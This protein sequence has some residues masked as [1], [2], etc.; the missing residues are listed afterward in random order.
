VEDEDAGGTPALRDVDFGGLLD[1]VG[2]EEGAGEI[3]DG[4]AAP[5]HDEAAAVGD[6]G[7]VDAFEVF[8]VGFGDEVGDFR[9]IDAD[10][11]AFLGFGDGEFGAVEAVVFFRDGIEVDDERGRDFADGDGDAAGAEVVAD[12][13]FAG[14][15]RVAEE[16]LDFALG[17]GVAFLDFGGVFEGGVVCSLDEPVA[18]P[19]PSR[20]VRP[21]MRR[22]TSPG[23]GVPRKT[24][25]RGAA[26]TTAPI[27]RRLAT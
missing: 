20:P 23:A 3:D 17:G 2:V 19:T 16:A 6:V 13:D 11:H 4:F 15:F 24:W 7:D 9:G 27:S 10:G 18:P 22:M 1:A 8:L 25:E 5:G 14:E 12:F 21:P 26:A